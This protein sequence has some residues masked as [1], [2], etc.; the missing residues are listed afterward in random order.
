M[1]E[2]QVLS[3]DGKSRMVPLEGKPV[4]IGRSSA[5]DLCFPED[6]G[7]SRRHLT[8]EPQGPNWVIKDLDS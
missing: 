5:A 4:T 6:N 3:A 1:K 7:L 8:I 2:L